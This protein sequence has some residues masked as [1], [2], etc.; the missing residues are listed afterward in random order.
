MKASCSSVSFRI[1]IDFA[2]CDVDKVYD[3]IM[4]TNY[5]SPIPAC[6]LEGV[7]P[8]KVKGNNTPIGKTVDFA[9]CWLAGYVDR[10]EM[11]TTKDKWD[12]DYSADWITEKLPDG[13][14]YA[15][16]PKVITELEQIGITVNE[17]NGLMMGTC[18]LICEV[19]Y[20]SFT[21]DL[22]RNANAIVES[23]FRRFVKYYKPNKKRE[24]A[25][26]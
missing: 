26:V 9:L 8:H 24:L 5:A 16:K 6:L 20:E 10:N 14:E 4:P 12:R 13:F 18:H 22:V 11:C 21:P 15:T 1:D 23:V 7:K 17:W 19:P 25:T 2:G 3:E